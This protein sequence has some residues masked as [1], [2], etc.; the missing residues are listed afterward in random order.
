MDTLQNDLDIEDHLRMLSFEPYIECLAKTVA[1]KS[2]LLSAASSFA[3][4]P[5]T[6]STTV[7]VR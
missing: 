4:L 2:I 1:G 7:V 3:L 6:S 5:F